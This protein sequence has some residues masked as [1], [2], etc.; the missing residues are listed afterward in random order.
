MGHRRGLSVVATLCS[1]VL[2]ATAIAA[3]PSRP[4][5]NSAQ[6]MEQRIESLLGQ[7][8]L[9]EKT[10]LLQGIYPP[11][12]GEKQV[13]YIAGVPRLGIPPLRLA[14]GPVGV[15]D[16]QPAT[17]FPAAAAMAAS[18]DPEL[19][20][21]TGAMIGRESRARGYQVIYG[22]MVNIVR[23]PQSGR[24]F[25]TYGEDPHLAGQLAGGMIRG[26]QS[27][28]VAGQVKH[29]AANNQERDRET[30]T[31][32][33]DERTLREIYLPPFTSATRDAGAWS[34]MCAYNQVNGQ[35]SC[36]NKF[37][38]SDVLRQQYG[39]DG[40]I[41]SDY[42]ATHS[43][44]DSAVASLD[45]EFVSTYYGDL[46]GAVRRGE[47][48]ESVVTDMARRALRLLFRTGSFDALPRLSADPAAGAALARRQAAAGSVLL[49][50]D[51]AVLPLAA[52]TTKLAVSG[53]WGDRAHTGGGGSS[54]VTPYPEYTVDPVSGLRA[55]G[56]TVDY[57]LGAAAP[58]P[59]PA[60]ALS[61]V[62]AQYFSNPDLAGNPVLSRSEA[63]IDADWQG[64]S[65]A[66]GV[67]ATNWSA[68]WTGLLVAP[69]TGNYKLAST[70]DDG[71][72]VILDGRQIV[73]NWYDHGV[74]TATSD[75]VRLEAGGR[76]R[77]TVEYYQR[78]GGSNLTFGWHQPGSVDPDIQQ[79]VAQ[80]KAADA[81]VVVVGDRDTEGT[82]RPDIDLEGNQN[83]LVAAV[84][85]AQPRTVVV[86]NTGGPVTMPWVD[87]APA[88]LETWYPGEQDG[89]ALGDLLFGDAE[90]GG[91]LP[92][93]FP[94]GLDATPMRTP[95]QYPGQDGAYTYSEGLNV[96]YRWYDSTGTAPLFPFGHGLSYTAF[97]YSGLTAGPPDEAGT[98]PV[99]FDVTNTGARPGTAVP[100]IYLSHPA[101]NGEPPRVLR[102]FRAVKL[103]PGQTQ[104]V[105]LELTRQDFAIWTGG[106]FAVPGGRFILTLGTSSRHLRT[107][108]PVDLA[109]VALRT[110]STGQITGSGAKCLTVAESDDTPGTHV[111]LWNC[112]LGAAQRWHVA[113]DDT[114][115]VMTRCLDARDGTARIAECTGQRWLLDSAGRL[116][117]QATKRCLTGPD[118]APAVVQECS[119][120]P[121]QRWRLP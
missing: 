10:V 37:L 95:E 38:L 39:F 120:S 29:V 54:A 6:P 112:G 2:S 61:E 89:N 87:G 32:N 50:N 81:A 13:G 73:D 107:Q 3:E 14:D 18:F 105:R 103:A 71:S 8:T 93:T 52:G 67:P 106:R 64:G 72:R 16:G 94:T 78:G 57:A 79:A 90:P 116:V 26:L 51:R 97:G 88:I 56:L 118:G 48:P 100:Q 86:L 24:N 60:S 28:R 43:T 53:P 108:V 11:P 40:V 55:R 91:R 75:S 23:V 109:P 69:A 63:Q 22:P 119:D 96:G 31:S 101:G 104:H 34:A 19:V 42:P 41:G 46:A 59:V 92:M 35:W 5:L 58:H 76:Y 113:S 21:E 1:L 49:K 17:A 66:P 30:S 80:A 68:R 74:V 45:Q 20:A 111:A 12:A 25:E 65:P 47:L 27:Q 121:A 115:R 36:E 62:T 98:V 9:D 85:A 15:R 117:D 70:S 77:F 84:T 83:E 44:V 99:E 7:L 110:G 114:I 4:W 33:V 102:G 82:D